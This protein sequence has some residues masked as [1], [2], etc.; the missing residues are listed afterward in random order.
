[1]QLL[2]YAAL[3]ATFQSSL[4]KDVIELEF[5]NS[6]SPILLRHIGSPILY[7]TDDLQINKS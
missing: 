2:F 4:T 5:K 7:P 6:Y 3:F 1:M